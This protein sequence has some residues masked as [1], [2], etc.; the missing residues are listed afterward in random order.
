M[1]TMNAVL[2][3]QGMLVLAPA[4]HASVA[5]GVISQHSTLLN[6]K[7]ERPRGRSVIDSTG[8]LYFLE[9]T[10]SRPNHDMRKAT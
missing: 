3:R 1:C 8:L 5:T 6:Q 10:V 9:R 7:T 2:G 4:N